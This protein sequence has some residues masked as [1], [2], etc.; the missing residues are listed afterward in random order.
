MPREEAEERGLAAFQRVLSNGP[1]IE[2][3]HHLVYYTH[4]EMGRLL[5]CMGRKEEA[6]KNFDLILSGTSCPLSLKERVF[7]NVHRFLGKN[8]EVNSHSRKGK[9]SFEVRFS[10]P[11]IWGI[12]LTFAIVCIAVT[13]ACRRRC[14]RARQAFVKTDA[15][16]QPASSSLICRIS[17]INTLAICNDP[18]FSSTGLYHKTRTD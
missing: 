13:Y 3:D 14:A 15:L 11:R 6:R 16:D 1:K 7:S 12:N 4:F 10:S 2:L 8:L 17:Y 18:T 5:A 9:Y